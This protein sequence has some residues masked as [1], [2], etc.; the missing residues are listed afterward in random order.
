MT[1]PGIGPISAVA[2]VVALERPDT[3]KDRSRRVVRY[4]SY[5]GMARIALWT[6]IQRDD[7]IDAC[8]CAARDRNE[9]SQA[10][11]R[12]STT[13]RGIRIYNGDMVLRDAAR[14]PSQARIEIAFL[15]KMATS[16]GR[17]PCGQ[18]CNSSEISRYGSGLRY[19]G[20]A[21]RNEVFFRRDASA[22][23]FGDASRKGRHRGELI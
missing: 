23:R 22:S 15:L 21:T 17:W 4:R 20:G 5:R 14:Q 13:E 7:L 11:D 6:G 16:A 18:C 10:P 8:A 19:G 2:Y 1:M 3:F 9:K 12:F